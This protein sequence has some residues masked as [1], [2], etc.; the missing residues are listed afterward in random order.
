MY[1]LF[2]IL[3]S[4]ARWAVI[5]LTLLAVVGGLRGLQ[6]GGSWTPA[7]RRANLLATIALDVQLLLGLGLYVLFSPFTTEALR[8]FGA[9]MRSP[10]LRFWAV[11]HLA[12]MMAALVLAHVGNVSARKASTD[13]ARHLRSTMFFG[14]V[15]LLIVLGTPWPGL[16]NGRPLFRLGF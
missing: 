10:A 1:S 8:G 3:H 6:S 12:M 4:W 14:I 2:L 16:S 7:N 9:A 15:L 5:V 13:Q 11:E